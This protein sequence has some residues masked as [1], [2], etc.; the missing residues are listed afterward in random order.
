MWRWPR[1]GYSIPATGRIAHGASPARSARGCS[2]LDRWGQNFVPKG[3]ILGHH[4]HAAANASNAAT[5]ASIT[6]T[7]K[8][9][10]IIIR[11]KQEAPPRAGL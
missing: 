6:T 3:S 1:A 7:V 4:R 11:P 5:N 9:C 10:T 8:G 2:R